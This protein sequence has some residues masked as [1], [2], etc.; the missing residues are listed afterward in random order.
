MGVKR[1]AIQIKRKNSKQQYKK[2]GILKRRG[3]KKYLPHNTN[4]MLIACKCLNI[5][6]KSTANNLPS[7]MPIASSLSNYDDIAF[8]TKSSNANQVKAISSSSVNQHGNDGWP[9]HLEDN[10]DEQPPYIHSSTAENLDCNQL[11]FFRTVNYHTIFNVQ[12]G[13]VAYKRFVLLTQFSKT[14]KRKTNN[15]IEQF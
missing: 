3:K 11:Q 10:H 5:T 9:E 15:A 13:F 14:K 8:K 4:K 1:P 6:L 12:Y 7:A 2:N